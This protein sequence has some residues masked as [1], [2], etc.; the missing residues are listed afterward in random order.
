MEMNSCKLCDQL[1]PHA[2]RIRLAQEGIFW[3]RRH[4]VQLG[5]FFL[6]AWLAIHL[7]SV[8]GACVKPIARAVSV[9]GKVEVRRAGQVGW[10]AVTTGEKF[11]AGD[12]VH[13]GL[14]ARG[15][16]LL[17][18]HTLMRLNQQTTLTFPAARTKHTW[19]DVLKGA[20]YFFS[21]TP[22][23]LEVETPFV[24]SGIEGTEFALQVANDRALL[25]VYEGQVVAKNRYGVLRLDSGQAA[26]AKRGQA[27]QAQLVV[28]L[29]K[30]VKWALYYPPLID[31]QA[32]AA[33]PDPYA[34]SLRKAV[35]H[36]Y[37]GKTTAALD[38]LGDVPHKGRTAEYYHLKTALLLSVGRVEAA[39][40]SI[41]AARQ[42]GGP[43]RRLLM[44]QS[45]H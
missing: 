13:T 12:S 28:D 16:I 15:G 14:N 25:W 45:L 10:Q 7:G 38:V 8:H 26:V 18:G 30:A 35:A 5:L 9:Q 29:Q 11:C 32:L 4:R 33:A 6:L 27:P 39:R 31:V 41:S 23:R 24:N 34:G 37:Q 17:R 36:Y 3:H 22:Q 21:R 20:L 19:L 43:P 42:A 1:H 2:T 44:S 40:K